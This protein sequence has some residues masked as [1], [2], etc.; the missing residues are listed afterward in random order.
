MNWNRT[1]ARLL[2]MLLIGA[3]LVLSYLSCTLKVDAPNG[4]GTEVRAGQSCP[5]ALMTGQKGT[6]TCS[7]GKPR[8]RHDEGSDGARGH[9]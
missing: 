4:V 7:Q 6:V 8:R 5:T 2:A 3:P 1:R 9:G